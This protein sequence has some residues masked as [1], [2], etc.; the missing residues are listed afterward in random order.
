[1]STPAHL[2]MCAHATITCCTGMPKWV[3]NLPIVSKTMA[4]SGDG[5]AQRA[6]PPLATRR[7]CDNCDQG[8]SRC[9]GPPIPLGIASA[10]AKC[11]P[12]P[13][14]QRYWP[15][16]QKVMS[17]SPHDFLNNVHLLYI[18]L[19]NN[20]NNLYALSILAASLLVVVFWLHRFRQKGWSQVGPGL[21]AVYGTDGPMMQDR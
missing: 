19:K 8:A 4:N 15:M 21:C 7:H 6:G 16:L 18:E 11:R 2:N 5:R 9:E 20:G 3:A 1:M 17:T 13:S 14:G 12:C 10:V